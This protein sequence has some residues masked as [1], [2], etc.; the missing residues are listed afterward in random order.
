MQKNGKNVGKMGRLLKKKK[1]KGRAR[2]RKI[3]SKK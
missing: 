3:N 1:K 2:N